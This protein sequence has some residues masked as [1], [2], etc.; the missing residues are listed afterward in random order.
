MRAKCSHDLLQLLDG[1]HEKLE[2]LRCEAHPPAG[3]FAQVILG[4][5]RQ[6]FRGSETDDPGIALE[7]VEAAKEFIDNG[8]IGLGFP[9]GLFQEHQC[10]SDV[11]QVL[12]AFQVEVVEQ[13]LAQ[14]G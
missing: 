11:L 13:V 3:Q 4:G 10:S 12:I 8:A 9:H 5:V 14:F 7:R 2:G 6:F 1:A